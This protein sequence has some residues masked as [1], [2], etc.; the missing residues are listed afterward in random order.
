LSEDAP[1]LHSSAYDFANRM[2]PARAAAHASVNDSL[3]LGLSVWDGQISETAGGTSYALAYWGRRKMPIFIINP[4]E[5][6]FDR[7]Y[8]ADVPPLEVPFPRL[9]TANPTGVQTAVVSMLL[10]RI[11]GYQAM[12]EKDYESFFQDLLGSLSQAMATNKWFP[13][14]YGFG[15]EYLFVWENV[16]DAGTAAVAFMALL[17]AGKSK[18]P[19]EVNFSICLHS[20][21]VQMIVNPVLNQ[22]THEGAAVSKLRALSENLTPGLIFATDNFASLAAFEKASTFKCE[23]SGK[24]GVSKDSADAHVYQVSK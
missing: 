2:I 9:Y 13:A 15:G 7:L 5:P 11:T 17:E 22:Y 20:G 6:K 21:P 19:P 16:C 12:R 23:Y 10:L 8:D 18:C 3:L 4:T 14:R 24:V 1:E